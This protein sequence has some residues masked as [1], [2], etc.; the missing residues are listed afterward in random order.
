M[1]SAQASTVPPR[2]WIYGPWLDLIVGCG[3][4]SVPLL[5]ISYSGMADSLAW[6]VAFYALALLLN[7]PHYMATLYR[8]YHN[9]SDFRKYRLFTIHLTGLVLLTVILTHFWYGLLPWVFTL[10]LTWSPWHYTGQNYGLFMMYARRAGPSISSFTK[11]ILYSAFVLS[12]VVWFVNLHTGVSDQQLF[13][14]LG[15]PAAPGLYARLTLGAVSLGLAVVGFIRLHREI[16]WTR[17]VPPLMLFSTQAIW[18]LVPALLSALPD[19]RLQQSRYSIGVLALAHSAQYLWITSY[20]AKREAL[21][22]GAKGWHPLVYFAVLIV[23]GIAL[24]IPGPWV[25]SYFFHYDFT[26]SF[27]IFT[28]LVN[29]HHFILDGAIWKLRD[30][31]IAALLLSSQDRLSTAASDMSSQVVHGWRWFRSASPAARGLRISV[32]CLLLGLAALDQVRYVRAGRSDDEESLRGAAALNPYDTPVQ[33]R[34]ARKAADEG[35]T[36]S[37]VAAWKVA[38]AANPADPNPR[39]ALLAYLAKSN[40]FNEAYTI[41]QQSL[42]TSPRDGALLVDTG[43]LAA[44]LGLSQDAATYWQQALAAD[45]SQTRAHLYLGD[46]LDRHGHPEEA[47]PHYMIYLEKLAHAQPQPSPEAVLPVLVKLAQC[48]VNA[49]RGD[50]ALKAYDL[51]QTLAARV[52]DKKIESLAAINAA[53]LKSKTEDVNGALRAYQRALT[54]DEQADDRTSA[55]ADWYRYAIFLRSKN[56]PSEFAYASI[57]KAASAGGQDPSVDGAIATARRELER[58]LGSKAAEVRRDDQLVQ[59]AL[60]LRAK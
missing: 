10:Y 59:A 4:W 48:Q 58:A 23:G 46:H 56:F 55:A 57:I 8:A 11:R 27:L 9:E 29:L 60:E 47:A 41:A 42:A 35:N 21:T 36:D 51:A 12:Y 7:Y 44:Q 39:N 26:T 34:L 14:S 40:R 53:G 50:Q 24:F 31:R 28:A 1:A 2:L 33:M 13:V 38:I 15:I 25:A 52:G 49:G 22:E 5:L 37:A 54:L 30:G 32:A 17:M 19:I 6:P 45:P 20:Y 3:A 43:L 18:F 16:G